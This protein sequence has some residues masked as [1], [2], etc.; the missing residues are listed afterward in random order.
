VPGL[1]NVARTTPYLHDGQLP[2]LDAV[3]DHY[4]RLSPD[5]LHADGEQILKPL[6][7]QGTDRADLLAF[8]QTLNGDRPAAPR[9]Q[10]GHGD[11]CGR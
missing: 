8:L 2:T 9:P 10:P 1:R 5:R 6:Q 4:A 3:L 11:G 7:L